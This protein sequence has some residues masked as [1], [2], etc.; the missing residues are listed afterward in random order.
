[1]IRHLVL[2]TLHDGVSPDGAAVR[3]ACAAETA[4]AARFPEVQWVFGPNR[5][6]RAGAA[7]FAGVGDFSSW[8]ALDAFL[9]DAT[10]REAGLLWRDLAD[11]FVADLE[12]DQSDGDQLGVDW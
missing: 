4:L 10:H 6:G 8:A 11:W 5:N 2:F 12:I 7:D 9:A 3:R 1:M